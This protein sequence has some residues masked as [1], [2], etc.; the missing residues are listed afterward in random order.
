MKHHCLLP[1]NRFKAKIFFFFDNKL[2]LF[3][4]YILNFCG[5][6]Y[7]LENYEMRVS[8]FVI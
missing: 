1:L 3:S 4:A 7:I 5:S 2:R 8:D 6:F